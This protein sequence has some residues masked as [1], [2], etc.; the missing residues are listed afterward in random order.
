LI[1]IR[2]CELRQ[3]LNKVPNRL[4]IPRIRERKIDI[5]RE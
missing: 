1:L 5:H 3:E 4:Q 2:A